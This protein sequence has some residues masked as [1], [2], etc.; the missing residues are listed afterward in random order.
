MLDSAN[1]QWE[2]QTIQTVLL[3]HITE[4]RRARRWGIFF[5]FAIFAFIIII[6]LAS[7]KKDL[8]QPVMM[9]KDHTALIDIKGEIGA[10]QNASADNIRTALRSAFNNNHVKGIVL[11]I[12]SPGGSPVQARQVFDEIQALK[13]EHPDIRIYAA[14]ED[15]GTSAGYLIATAAEA[16]YSDKT[17]LV[18]SIGVRLESFGFVDVMHKVGVERRSYVA[19]N[20]KDMLDPFLPRNPADERFIQKQLQTVHEA[21]IQNVKEGRGDRLHETPDLYSG[22]FW[23]GEEALALGLIDAYGDAYYVAKHIVKAE[24][25][26]DYTTGTNLFDRLAHR[27]GT[28]MGQV[29]SSQA[30]FVFKGLQ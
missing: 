8:S 21:F 14:I 30:G 26:V 13:T 12:N 22:L 11:R 15:L 3:E 25:V 16:I 20:H 27:L 17:S 7:F 9:T 10:D 24:E 6:L 18:G 5:K 1:T 28:S 4:Q 2:R 23:C 19:G 29:L